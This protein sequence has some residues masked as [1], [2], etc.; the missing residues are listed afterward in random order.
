MEA[1]PQRGELPGPFH[2][3]GCSPCS[4]HQA[5]SGQDPSPMRFFYRLVYRDGETE[6]VAGDDELSHKFFS[7][8]TMRPSLVR[9]NSL[10]RQTVVRLVKARSKETRAA[11]SR[12]GRSIRLLSP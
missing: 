12:K 11:I 9:T 6:V 7:R 10:S 4:N 2:R 1:H 5:G 8:V 3:I